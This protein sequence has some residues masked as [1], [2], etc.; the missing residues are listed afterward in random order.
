[1]KAVRKALIAHIKARPG[2]TSLSTGGVFY[3]IAPPKTS[4][5]FTI[6]Q[7]MSGKPDH[8]FGGVAHQDDLYLVKALAVNTSTKSGQELAEEIAEALETAL[9]DAVLVISGRQHFYLRREMDREMI[10]PRGNDE[11][12]H[13]VGA[14]WRL[15]TAPN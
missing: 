1:M 14:L 13:H 10:E 5:P 12:V 6:V 8:T 7:R 4:H 11:A 9:S 2:V 3:G 15:V